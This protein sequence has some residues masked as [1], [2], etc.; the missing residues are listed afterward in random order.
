MLWSPK[1]HTVFKGRLHQYTVEWDNHP[2][3]FL[4]PAGPALAV[5]GPALAPQGINDAEAPGLLETV[6]WMAAPKHR[7]TIE[8]N[9][10]RRRNPSKLIEIKVSSRALALENRCRGKY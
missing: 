8:V 9:R 6:V 4:S 7:R 2:P 1:L 10:C 5:Q 3:L